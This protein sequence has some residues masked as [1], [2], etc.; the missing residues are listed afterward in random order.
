MNNLVLIY[1]RVTKVTSANLNPWLK[2]RFHPS[3]EASSHP[4]DYLYI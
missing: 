2:Y 3:K 4:D 1:D